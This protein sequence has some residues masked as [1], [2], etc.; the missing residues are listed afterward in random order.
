[1]NL[2]LLFVF[3]FFPSLIFCEEIPVPENSWSLEITTPLLHDPSPENIVM[4]DL[5][6][7]CIEKHLLSDLRVSEVNLEL[8]RTHLGLTITVSGDD[9]SNILFLHA[10]KSIKEYVPDEHHFKYLKGLLLGQY[11]QMAVEAPLVQAIELMTSILQLDYRSEKMKAA[12]M[13]GIKF[14]QFQEF[15]LH[16]FDQSSTDGF[17]SGNVKEKL[18]RQVEAKVIDSFDVLLP[19]PR[20]Q[21]RFVE[22]NRMPAEMGPVY[23]EARRKCEGCAAVLAIE[24]GPFS[25]E[26]QAIQEILIRLFP[27]FLPKQLQNQVQELHESG[28]ILYLIVALQSKN[29]DGRDLLSRIEVSCEEFIS[30]LQEQKFSEE[31]FNAVKLSLI[32]AWKQSSVALGGI[33]SFME[34]MSFSV[35][36]DPWIDHKIK[37]FETLSYGAFSANIQ[38][39]LGKQNKHRVAVV[40]SGMLPEESSLQYKRATSFEQMKSGKSKK[41]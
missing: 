40:F 2:L 9:R 30:E 26:L 41:N 33:R 32:D 27:R 24:L 37:A 25:H 35:S 31:D 29:H 34:K 15:V 22:V 38:A 4:A 1:M 11:Q 14:P 6:V 28:D 19:Y 8:K 3:F 36:E 13:R 20:D 39:I 23:Y 17:F 18:A 5:Y 16:V 21:C 12:A 7:K 10:I